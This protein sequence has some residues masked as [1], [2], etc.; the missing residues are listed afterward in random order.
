MKR[1]LLLS[2][3]HPSTDPRIVYKTAPALASCFEVICAL[4]E[5]SSR[6]RP[7]FPGVKMIWLPRFESLLQRIFFCH[8]VILWKCFRLRPDYVHI[9][10]PELIPLAILFQWLGAEIIYE[11]Q[12][13]M[14]KKFEIKKHNNHP[15]FKLLFRYL[16]SYARKQF[17]CIFTDDSYL[18]E[19]QNLKRSSVITRNF[20]SLTFVDQYV[21]QNVKW[22]TNQRSFFYCGVISMER[23]FDVLVAAV[24]SLM[25]RY[26]DLTVHLFGPVR[27]SETEAERLPDYHKVKKHFI[28]YGYTDLKQALPYAKHCLAGIA[29]LKPV[30]DYPD[31]Y[32][33]KIFEYMALNLP[34]ITSDFPLYKSVIDQAGCGFCITPDN[35]PLLAKTMEWIIAN[36]D[37]ARIM[38][39]QGRRAVEKHYNWEQEQQNLLKFY[40]RIGK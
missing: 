36:P 40:S 32:T 26:P 13:N 1:A 19:Y 35:A 12:E 21:V 10:V 24:A 30:A 6:E 5:H 22:Q 31:S 27:F 37:M 34:V 9:F 25:H 4:P 11:V 39:K 15:A 38:G 28:F 2:S 7:H 17:H 8:P 20:V 23:C 3:I 18:N 16:D 33:T 29:L 14:F